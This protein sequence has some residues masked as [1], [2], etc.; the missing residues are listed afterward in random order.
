MSSAKGRSDRIVFQDGPAR[1]LWDGGDIGARAVGQRRVGG[2]S[3]RTS[4]RLALGGGPRVRRGTRGQRAL[5]LRHGQ[6][7]LAGTGPASPAPAVSSSARPSR[8]PRAAASSAPANSTTNARISESSVQAAC[9]TP[10]GQSTASPAATRARSSATRTQPPPST[11]TSQAL[12][13]LECR[14]MEARRANASSATRPRASAW[15]TWDATPVVPSG[16]SGRR[17]PTPKRRISIAQPRR[18]RA[19]FGRIVDSGCANFCFE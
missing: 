19:R 15:I 6:R 10:A 9:S 17:C 12:F 1:G 8:I 13:G 4:E 3:R 2:G 18:R 11:I 16:P 5:T 7:P 14:S